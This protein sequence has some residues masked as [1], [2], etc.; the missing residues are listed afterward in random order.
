MK[1]FN[2]CNSNLR[3]TIDDSNILLSDDITNEILVGT[4]PTI[5]L[6]AINLNRKIV[7]IF[8]E[9]H[10]DIS[11]RLLVKHSANININNFALALPEN[12]A[13]INSNQASSPLCVATNTGTT[14][15]KFTVVNKL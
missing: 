13:Y 14:L 9:Q 8:T 7:K 6:A 4:T 5:L 15:I 10:S 12:Y 11:T 2:C 1:I 3:Q